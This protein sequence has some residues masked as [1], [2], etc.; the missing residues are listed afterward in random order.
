[1]FIL[2]VVNST[3][4][5]RECLISISVIVTITSR[6]KV[7]SATLIAMVVN[8]SSRKT[9]LKCFLFLL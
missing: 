4:Q 5:I 1:M 6:A 7:F 9:I 3:P 8:G 2:F